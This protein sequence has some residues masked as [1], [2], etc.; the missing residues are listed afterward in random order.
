MLQRHRIGLENIFRKKP[1]SKKLHSSRFSSFSKIP[2]VRRW[3]TSSVG[4][5][6]PC[7]RICSCSVRL[8]ASSTRISDRFRARCN[9]FI[10]CCSSS[11]VVDVARMVIVADK[12]TASAVD[13]ISSSA[14]LVAPGAS[15][16]NSVVKKDPLVVVEPSLTL[17]KPSWIDVMLARIALNIVNQVKGMTSTA[18][19]RIV[20]SSAK[21]QRSK[22][23]RGSTTKSNWRGRE[24]L[25]LGIILNTCSTA[26]KPALV[27]LLT[28]ANSGHSAGPRGPHSHSSSLHVHRRHEA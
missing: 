25:V 7:I 20:T 21:V 27:S 26:A 22:N 16:D 9:T 6:C 23:H 8:I 12:R 14:V 28:Q 1:C 19:G 18:A 15:R 11:A 17:A 24:D 13:C 2:T 10:M 4:P 5:K 3:C